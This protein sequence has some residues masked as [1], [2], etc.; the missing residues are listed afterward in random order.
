M[1]SLVDM[2]NILNLHKPE[3]SMAIAFKSLTDFTPEQFADVVRSSAKNIMETAKSTVEKT[4]IEG[5]IVLSNQVLKGAKRANDLSKVL[6][7]LSQKIAP[8]AIAPNAK[9]KAR[10]TAKA[11]PAAKKPAAKL[12]VKTRARK[13]AAA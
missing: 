11:K 7:L 2:S 5:R 4:Q 12:V 1:R 9:P 10:A 3:H 13:A 6:F 8:K